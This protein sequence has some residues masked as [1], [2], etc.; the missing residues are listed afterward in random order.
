MLNNIPDD[1][2]RL[3]NFVLW[4]KEERDGK[5]TKIPI[6]PHTGHNASVTNPATWG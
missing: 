3:P 5:I 4:K 1:F 2:K 6:C